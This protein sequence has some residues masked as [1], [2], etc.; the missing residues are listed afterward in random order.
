MSLIKLKRGNST[1]FT[2]VSLNE[3]EPA[4]VLDTGKLYI[5]N[6][7]EKVLI[8]PD[9]P[10]SQTA[11]KL[12]TAR[13]I[14]LSGDVSGSTTFDGSQNVTINATLSNSGVPASTYTKVTVNS[15]GLVTAGSNITEADIPTLPLSKITGTGT[16]ASKNVG[17]SAGNIPLLNAQG[18]LDDAVL[19]PLAINDTFVVATQALMTSL[20]AQV[21][22]VAIRTD[23][24]RSY[25]LKALPAT[26]LG[27]WQELLSPTSPVQSVAGKT[28]NVTLT[29]SDVGAEP[30]FSKS[31]AFNKNFETS[32]AVIKVNG[33]ATAGSS[34]NVAR[35]D[36]VHPIDSSRAPLSSPTFTGAPKAPTA[37]AS[38]ND[39]QIATTAF[40][41]M[42]G[43]LTSTDVLDGGTF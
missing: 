1:N 12:E 2:N 29:A 42:Q 32:S 23:I 21:G 18:K 22:D 26:T 30:A 8:N 3:G 24:S 35:A 15:K 14:G 28:G 19:P 25:I 33:S 20:S 5:G 7:T 9:M 36:H 11:A 39:T 17:N 10:N 16:A 38:A 37:T 43:Y 34:S 41:K 13:Q 31:T 40:V 27:N 4:F 6:G